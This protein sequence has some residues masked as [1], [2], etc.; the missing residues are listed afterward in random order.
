MCWPVKGCCTS[1]SMKQ[2][3]CCLPLT[4]TLSINVLLSCAFNIV[5]SESLR[6]YS[7]DI[8]FY[9]SFL[10]CGW[11]V[12]SDDEEVLGSAERRAMMSCIALLIW[13]P[14]SWEGKKRK[15]KYWE[16]KG[17]CKKQTNVLLGRQLKPQR[18]KRE[19]REHGQKWEVN[20]SL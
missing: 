11:P 5:G 12:P 13:T 10:D 19:E 3:L 2:A 18:Q 17:K 14:E 9:W 8:C 6:K 20:P 4:L 1:A 16:V 7:A 15:S